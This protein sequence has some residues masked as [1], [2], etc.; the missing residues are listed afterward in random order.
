VRRREFIT[1][2]GG[3][4]AAWPLAARAQQPTGQRRVGVLLVFREGNPAAQ[5]QL[6][7]LREALTKLGWTD[8]KNIKFEY[9]WVGNDTSFIQ[10]GAQELVALHPDLIISAASSPGTAAL[11]RE[12]RTIPILF[13]N[14]VDPVGQGFVTSLAR[15]GG[16]VTGFV[17]LDTSMAGK[18]LEL[19][20]QV[21]PRAR[22]IVIPFN[23]A[24]T[25]YAEL[26]L[27]YFKS[28]AEPLG[29]EIVAAPV[30]DMAGFES[31][32][33]AQ[34]GEPSTGLIPVPSTFIQANHAEIAAIVARYRLTTISF[35]RVFAEA[36]GLLSY[37][38][39]II[40]NYRRA[41]V[42]VDRILKGEKPSELPI[43]FPVKF[44]L[45]INLR[46]AKA[47]GLEIP[48]GVLA[49]ADEVIE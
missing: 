19:L 14:I 11:R 32:A 49:I 22:R 9:R 45:V 2:L 29:A 37:G 27:N 24:T 3:A 5:A 4:A 36:G 23:P 15:P 46:T 16:N 34:S 30:H 21:M 44:E 8:D 48:P 42:Y 33:A 39:D 25:P 10:R 31:L 26:Y 41:A 13:I 12:T 17:N 43:Q 35:N 40:D 20:R 7:A 6:G 47:L 1:L 38:N 18:W 28:N